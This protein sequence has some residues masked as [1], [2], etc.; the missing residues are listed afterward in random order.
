M[1]TANTNQMAE[2]LDQVK[3]WPVP[4]RITLARQ[5]LE[6]VEEKSGVGPP[7]RKSSLRSL[8]G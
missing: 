5:I 2:I 7:P 8:V 4:S 1:A 6:T 3:T